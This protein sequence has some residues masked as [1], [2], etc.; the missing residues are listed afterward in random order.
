MTVIFEEFL[1]LTNSIFE[2]VGELFPVNEASVSF[3]E[4]EFAISYIRAIVAKY[5]RDH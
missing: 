3:D 1:S 2:N 5:D 4:N